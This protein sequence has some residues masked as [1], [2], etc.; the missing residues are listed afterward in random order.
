MRRNGE[1]TIF[2]SDSIVLLRDR[3]MAN[4]TCMYKLCSTHMLLYHEVEAVFMIFVLFILV[5]WLEKIN[6]RHLG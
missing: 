1:T 4:M 2:S 3:E 6:E 5:G